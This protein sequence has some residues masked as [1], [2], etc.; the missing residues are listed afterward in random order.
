MTEFLL[1]TGPLFVLGSQTVPAQDQT[2]NN[3]FHSALKNT[4]S[5]LLTKRD[6]E[7]SY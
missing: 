7:T 1:A 6:E 2:I 3:C 4:R 5:Q